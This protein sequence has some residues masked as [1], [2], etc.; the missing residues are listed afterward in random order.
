VQKSVT[1][2][3]AERGLK[4]CGLNG[5]N[6]AMCVSGQLRNKLLIIQQIYLALE[7]YSRTICMICV[8]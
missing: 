2:P 8:V 4:D 7:F 6:I 1:L 3:D 5:P